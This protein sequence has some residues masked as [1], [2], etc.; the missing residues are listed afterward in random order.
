MTVEERNARIDRRL[1]ERLEGGLVEEVKG[2]LDS[3]VRPEEL[4]NYG[5]EYK[6]VTQH[7]L[8][9]IDYDTMFTLL[10]TAIHQ[11]AKR[12]MTF[13]RGMEAKGTLIHWTIPGEK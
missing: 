4:I 12:Q 13:Y 11:F 8:G 1:R 3:G 9:V 7:V 5:L 2:L 10:S 6:F